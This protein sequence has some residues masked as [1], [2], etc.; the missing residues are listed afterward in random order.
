LLKAASE[1][2]ARRGFE[3][4]TVREICRRAGANLAAV[5]YHFGGKEELYAQALMPAPGGCR[6]WEPPAPSSCSPEHR[7]EAFVRSFF[8]RLAGSDHDAS[9][10]LLLAREMV[11]PTAALDDV[12]ER[13]IRPQSVWLAGVLAELLGPSASR[14]EIAFAGMSVVGQILFYK[15]C[16]AVIRRLDPSMTPAKGDVQRHVRHVTDFTL[17]ALGARRAALVGSSKP[18]RKP[19][20][21]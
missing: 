5:N 10:A 9:Q 16:E 14:E 19:A 3:H 21:R 13:F 6:A 20:R 1:E 7:L 2:F 8:E 12:V 17:A 11:E 18:R 4:A 15:H